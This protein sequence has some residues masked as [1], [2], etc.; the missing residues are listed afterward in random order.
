VYPAAPMPVLSVPS[1]IPAHSL[2]V[3]S[4]APVS[5]DAGATGLQQSLRK[6]HDAEVHEAAVR[7]AME[8]ATAEERAVST[9]MAETKHPAAAADNTGAKQS[10]KASGLPTVATQKTTRSQQKAVAKKVVAPKASV[11]HH[12]TT[13]SEALLKPT[14]VQQPHR[15]ISSA[16]TSSLPV[17]ALHQ[18]ASTVKVATQAKKIQTGKIKNAVEIDE[19]KTEKETVGEQNEKTS[20]ANAAIAESKDEADVVKRADE[21]QGNEQASDG[22]AD[23]ESQDDSQN[24]QESQGQDESEGK[25]ESQNQDDSEVHETAKTESTQ[26]DGD[27]AHASSGSQAGDADEGSDEQDSEHNESN[28]ENDDTAP[29]HENDDS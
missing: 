23:N 7:K 28:N 17:K 4:D 18:A 11:I 24:E 5:E 8:R 27:N 19:A 14:S 22:A 21:T 25:D 13:E 1:H 10:T 6:K 12:R 26:S 29:A 16:K 9:K 15:L 20:E 2:A 3:T